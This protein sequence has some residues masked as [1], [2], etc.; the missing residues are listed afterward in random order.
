MISR[1]C[2]ILPPPLHVSDPVFT[3]QYWNS[4]ELRAAY[5]EAFK[6]YCAD[7]THTEQ[8]WA[9]EFRVSHME[10]LAWKAGLSCPT[11]E[12]IAAHAGLFR[13]LT[14]RVMRLPEVRNHFY[15]L[16]P[17]IR[18]ANV[19]AWTLRPEYLPGS[20][21]LNGFARK[22]TETWLS[23]VSSW[24]TAL[25]HATAGSAAQSVILGIVGCTSKLNWPHM[26]LIF[27]ALP[28]LNPIHDQLMKGQC[29]QAVAPVPPSHVQELARALSE[30]ATLEPMFKSPRLVRRRAAQA[31][32]I[33]RQWQSPALRT[34]Y[35]QILDE[36]RR[37]AKLS[38]EALQQLLG[39]STYALGTWL[40]A[41]DAPSSWQILLQMDFFEAVHNEVQLSMPAAEVAESAPPAAKRRKLHR[42][43]VEDGFAS[44]VVF[45]ANTPFNW[46]TDKEELLT[47]LPFSDSESEMSISDFPDDDINQMHFV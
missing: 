34:R 14:G 39:V 9:K 32:K 41:I 6:G 47:P 16:A 2:P 4:R 30:L 35:A 18:R 43:S 11:T 15:T 17:K 19:E 10:L 23:S 24:N 12:Q 40:A 44:A 27:T 7:G 33:A 22:Q 31:A 3:A 26:A 25:S 42:P 37:D 29:P 38:F 46:D 20:K 8:A 28:N 5:A 45:D 36:V 1:Q 13:E 21:R